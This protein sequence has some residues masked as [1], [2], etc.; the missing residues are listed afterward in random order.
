MAPWP[1]S[2]ISAYLTSVG[3]RVREIRYEASIAKITAIASGRNSEPAAPVRK[4]TGTNTMQIE[5]VDTKVGIAICCAPSRIA[6]S[7][8]FPASALR[9][10][11]SIATVASST[12]MPTAS[13]SPPSVI[14]LVVWPS[15]PSA[16]IEQ[17]IASGIESATIRVERQLPRKSRIMSAVRQAAST[18]SRTTPLSAARTKS[19]WSASR[20]ILR[21]A[22]SVVWIFGRVSRTRR[23]MSSVDAPPPFRIVSSAPRRPSWRTTLVCTAKPSCTWATSRMY[24]VAPPRAE[25]IGMS[26]IAWI[27]SGLEFRWT[28]YS[29]IPILAVPAG[30]IRFCALMAPATSV[31]E[32][33][34]A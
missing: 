19:D 17:R 28:V 2:W 24:T 11:F 23:T 13:A 22:G 30:R 6:V 10:M 15:A 32:S 21:L 25:R 29:R 27:A 1:C 8:G 18:A 31:G 7:S 5:S 33:P 26:L 20:S 14:T 3:T 4:K 9:W 16:M 12:R 34:W